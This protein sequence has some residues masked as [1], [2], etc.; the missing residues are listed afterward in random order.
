MAAMLIA[1]AV[2]ILFIVGL[3]LEML[4]SSPKSSVEWES[5]TDRELNATPDAAEAHSPVLPA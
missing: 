1:G 3:F 4:S 5:D 2:V